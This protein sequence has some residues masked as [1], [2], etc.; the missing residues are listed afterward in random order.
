MSGTLPKIIPLA[1]TSSNN[2]LKLLPEN[3]PT[4]QA[5][6]TDLYQGNS[7]NAEERVV[8]Q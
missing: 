8:N 5:P 2:R 7:L 3:L 4:T 1:I 6:A